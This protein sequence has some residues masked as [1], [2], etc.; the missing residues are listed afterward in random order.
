MSVWTVPNDLGKPYDTPV[1]T[2]RTRELRSPNNIIDNFQHRFGLTEK[3]RMA[4]RAS[5]CCKVNS[6]L[7]YHSL[8]DLKGQRLIP[9]TEKIGCGV[10]QVVMQHKSVESFEQ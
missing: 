3:W 4:G 1:K 8:L 10:V 5:L 6:G 7:L 9:L 2:R